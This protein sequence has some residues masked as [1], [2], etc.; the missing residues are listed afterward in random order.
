MTAVLVLCTSTAAHAHYPTL[1]CQA[2]TEVLVCKAGY[3]DGSSASGETVKV[4][5]YD[6]EL[7]YHQQTDAHSMVQFTYPQGEFYISFDPGH[8]QAAEVDYI[9]LKT[10]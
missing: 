1:D 7:L 8:D 9:E 2:A 4:F 3:S 6:D 5:S 10:P